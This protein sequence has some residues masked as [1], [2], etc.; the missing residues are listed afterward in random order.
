MR[1][2]ESVHPQGVG[3]PRRPANCGARTARSAAS[4]LWRGLEPRTWPS[5]PRC[6]QP[7]DAPPLADHAGVASP[8]LPRFRGSFGQAWELWPVSLANLVAAMRQNERDF[9]AA[10]SLVALHRL[11]H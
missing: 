6:Q 7:G 4:R 10:E 3:N 8:F 2:R 11:S 5:A 9:L 1:V